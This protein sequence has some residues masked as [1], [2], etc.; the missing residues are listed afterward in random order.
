MF[1]Q[2]N[3]TDA[4]Y[5]AGL[6]LSVLGVLLFFALAVWMIWRRQNSPPSPPPASPVAPISKQNP[7]LLP[8]E[9][10]NP[11]SAEKLS[12]RSSALQG[13]YRH[14]KSERLLVTEEGRRLFLRTGVEKSGMRYQLVAS[15]QT[16]ALAILLSVV[17]AETDPRASVQAEALFASLLAHPTHNL[18]E[19]TSW[20]FMPDLP[21][22]PRL[23]PDPHAELW[24]IYS[25]LTATK[26]WPGLN[27]FHYPELLH[28]RL[29][30]LNKYVE[31]LPAASLDNLPSSGCLI[32]SIQPLD[33]GLNWSV[34]DQHRGFTDLTQW[35]DFRSEPDTSRL[36]LSL[37]QAGLLAL[38]DHDPGVKNTMRDA[39]TNL[40]KLVDE[41]LQEGS[42]DRNFSAI[43]MLSCA[44]PALMA[45]QEHDRSERIWSNLNCAQ[46]DKN[47]GLGATL[48]LLA[49]A[50]LANQ[51]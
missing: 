18:P 10:L 28:K 26:R 21:R 43:A 32:K 22:S 33:P 15:T 25:M 6:I 41:Y 20:K 1:P 4:T 27:R 16:Q 48:R 17:M 36:G 3:P 23:D 31:T 42:I 35:S 47:D 46:P 8:Y 19:L 44:A 37:L 34:L 40:I 5:L 30:A 51:I 11:L 39:H 13:A 49:L 7:P 50:L 24:V 29:Q 2:L 9:T 38:L 14:W 12:E 45:L